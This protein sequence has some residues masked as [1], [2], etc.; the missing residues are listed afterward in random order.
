MFL[1]LGGV[2]KWMH[3]LPMAMF[4]WE[5]SVFILHE[6][7]SRWFL[8][9]DLCVFLNATLHLLH[10]KLITMD[11]TSRMTFTFT[12]GRSDI[13]ILDLFFVNHRP[14][15]HKKTITVTGC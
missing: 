8:I 6:G 2:S 13:S 14:R 1:A 10:D 9:L 12:R 15:M 4:V 3:P 5:I 11:V 7:G